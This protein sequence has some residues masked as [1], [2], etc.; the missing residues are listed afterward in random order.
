MFEQHN[1]AGDLEASFLLVPIFLR[2]LLQELGEDGV[3]EKACVYNKSSE[4]LHAHID[5]Q[6]SFGDIGVTAI[7]GSPPAS[8]SFRF[9][10]TTATVLVLA[11]VPHQQRALQLKAAGSVSSWICH[12]LQLSD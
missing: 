8:V 9:M 5:R 3:V 12:S 10:S 1:I 11:S 7:L 6:V 2:R 4:L